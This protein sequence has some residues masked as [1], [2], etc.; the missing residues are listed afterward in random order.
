MINAYFLDGPLAG[1]SK[2]IPGVMSYHF[3][4]DDGVERVYHPKAKIRRALFDV[5]AFVHY[6][7][8]LTNPQ[9]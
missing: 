2:L 1:Q 9:R 4:D 7:S 8:H 5:W 3:L 6:Q